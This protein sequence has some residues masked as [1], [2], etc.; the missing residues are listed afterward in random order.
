VSG[1]GDFKAGGGGGGLKRSDSTPS[2]G[3][4]GWLKRLIPFSTSGTSA[5]VGSNTSS[6]SKIG[7][8]NN[9]KIHKRM[10]VE[11]EDDEEEFG[12][13]GIRDQSPGL[14]RTHGHGNDGGGGG[15][16]GGG[17][18]RSRSSPSPTYEAPPKRIRRF[19][20]TKPLDLNYSRPTRGW[21][22]VPSNMIRSSP[23]S[24]ALVDTYSSG[25]KRGG[26]GSRGLSGLGGGGG[27][28][29]GIRRSE[30]MGDLGGRAREG[31]VTRSMG[32]NGKGGSWLGGEV[33]PVSWSIEAL[34]V[35]IKSLTPQKCVLR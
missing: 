27:G 20:P 2:T 3:A 34:A 33:D 31:S 15:G 13:V 1:D 30:T 19:S 10:D 7:I 12:N 5:V 29:G 21:N 11:D 22:D 35:R 4:F 6:G 8:E 18:H 24:S 23:S 32:R 9:R 25:V 16:G 28:G 14:K 26:A 17:H